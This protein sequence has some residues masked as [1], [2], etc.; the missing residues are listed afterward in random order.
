MAP[1]GFTNLNNDVL[2]CTIDC[3]AAF[4]DRRLTL[5]SLS[6]A[7][8]KLR[9]LCSPVL[10]KELPADPE[11]SI[12]DAFVQLVAESPAMRACTR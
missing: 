2:M 1:V 3:V 6:A 7:C 4:P 12:G 5:F 11:R 8:K 9:I 10:F